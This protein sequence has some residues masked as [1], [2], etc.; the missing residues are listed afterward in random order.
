LKKKD[1]LKGVGSWDCEVGQDWS[2]RSNVQLEGISES[3][4]N[5]SAH[6]A[7]SLLADRPYQSV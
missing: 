1:K 6:T 3:V 7:V 4:D 5:V 2:A